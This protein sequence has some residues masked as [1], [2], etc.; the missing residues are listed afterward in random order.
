MKINE[1]YVKSGDR[2]FK[3]LLKNKEIRVKYEEE[4]INSEI[5]IAVRNI[6][7]KAK[8]SQTE[9]AK[10]IGT[11]QSVIARLESGN[12][13][14]TPSLSLLA[15]IGEVCKAHLEL[16]YRFKHAS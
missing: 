13:T 3:D 16:A 11:S 15:R 8:Y 14:R 12:D 5:A 10:K 2:F 7:I 1:K 4:K 6:R 9:L